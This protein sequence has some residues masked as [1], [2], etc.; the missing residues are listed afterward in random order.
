MTIYVGNINNKARRVTKVY[1]GNISGKARLV[2]K[3]YVGNSSNKAVEVFS[4]FPNIYQKVEYIQNS[5]YTQYINIGVKPNSSYRTI[6]EFAIT[7]STGTQYVRPIF[8]VET[9]A[10]GI[11]YALS[12]SVYNN[13]NYLQAHWGDS[14]QGGTMGGMVITQGE[15]HVAD[16]NRSGSFYVD[17]TLAGTSSTIF[18]NGGNA[19]LFGINGYY[20]NPSN[21][22]I[23]VYRLRIYNGSTLVRDMHPCYLKSNTQT[24][25]MWDAVNKVFYNNAGTGIFDKGP[26]VN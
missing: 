8:G 7:V 24:V 23:K 14:T 4:N 20:Y 2:T 11:S 16:L 6:L 17:D 13:E 26:D 21:A 18:A 15:K 3:V 19:Y 10:G 9:D 1:V 5:G 22:L 25:G 12:F